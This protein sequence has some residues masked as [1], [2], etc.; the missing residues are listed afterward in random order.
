MNEQDIDQKY[1]ELLMLIFAG[2]PGIGR[3]IFASSI[4]TAVN[5][6]LDQAIA[7]LERDNAAG[8]IEEVQKLK[9]I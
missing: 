1:D 2:K 4:R 9:Y 8:V 3:N 7:I 6:K 5:I